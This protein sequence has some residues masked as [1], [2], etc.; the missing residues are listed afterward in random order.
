MT[1]DKLQYSIASGKEI[2]VRTDEQRP[3][4]LLPKL[5]KCHF[6]RTVVA[7]VQHWELQSKRARRPLYV[8]HL[9]LG[10]W[11][12]RVHEQADLA[13]VWHQLSQQLQPFRDECVCEKDHPGNI[14]PRAIETSNKVEFDRVRAYRKDDRYRCCCGFGGKRPGRSSHGYCGYFSTHEISRQAR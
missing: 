14:T 7:R 13:S 11:I 5:C 1:C 9:R 8:T 4:T 6:D 3:E 10:I 12:V 2:T